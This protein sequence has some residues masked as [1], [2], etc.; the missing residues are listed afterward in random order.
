MLLQKN[1]LF[2]VISGAKISRKEQKYIEYE[3]NFTKIN[4]SNLI[5]S[6]KIQLSRQID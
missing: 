6:W 2:F 5:K 3:F 1:M 4:S